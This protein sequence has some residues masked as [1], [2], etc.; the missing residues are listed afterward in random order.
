MSEEIHQLR[1]PSG[2]TLSAP[3]F[4][5]VWAEHFKHCRAAVSE[6]MCPRHATPLKPLPAKPGFIAGD[7]DECG[8]YYAYEVGEEMV[9]EHFYFAGLPS[10]AA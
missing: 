3:T 10:W 7:C 9:H 1:M 5:E 6:G 4:A 8:T 2:V